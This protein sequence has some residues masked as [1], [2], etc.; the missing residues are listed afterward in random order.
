MTYPSRWRRM[1]QQTGW[2][3][4]CAISIFLATIFI[5]AGSAVLIG[6]AA[7]AAFVWSLL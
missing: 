2:P 7:A 1:Q 3:F 5:V 6:A 4:G